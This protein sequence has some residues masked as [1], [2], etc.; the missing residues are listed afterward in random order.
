MELLSFD[1]YVTT[2]NVPEGSLSNVY[3]TGSTGLGMGIAERKTSSRSRIHDLIQSAVI[4]CVRT[5]G[6]Y[7]RSRVVFWSLGTLWVVRTDLLCSL[8]L[9]E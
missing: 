2:T 6:I 3:L 9:A 4:L 7:E 8:P 5:Y 1:V